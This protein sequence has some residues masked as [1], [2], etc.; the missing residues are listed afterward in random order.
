[1]RRRDQ[2]VAHCLIGIW[3]TIAALV[4]NWKKLPK[5]K[6]SSWES[7]IDAQE[8][9]NYSFT[10]LNSLFFSFLAIFV[11]WNPTKPTC[12]FPDFC[13]KKWRHF[14][15]LN[16]N[17]L[18]GQDIIKHDLRKK[19]N[20]LP[21]KN[22]SIGFVA[23][24]NCYIVSKKWEE[25]PLILLVLRERFNIYARYNQESSR[26]TPFEVT[27]GF[28]MLFALTHFSLQTQTESFTSAFT[29][30]QTSFFFR[31]WWDPHSMR[32]LS[33]QRSECYVRSFY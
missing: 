26:L 16:Q 14:I 11:L 9:V 6:Q 4:G 25:Y 15:L 22:M 7:F 1:M 27:I 18:I 17:F 21:R 12:L 2:N 3:K 20:F 8:T 31:S 24:I 19:D 29:K 13:I 5:S 32:S 28:E 30:C 33:S 10:V 23:I